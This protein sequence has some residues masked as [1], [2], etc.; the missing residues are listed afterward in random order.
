MAGLVLGTVGAVIG[1][2]FGL[3]SVGWMV[4]SAIG[5]MLDKKSAP[6][7]PMLN[8]LKIM[9]SAYGAHISRFWGTVRA[10]GKLID[11]TDKIPHAQHS[12]QGNKGG[13]G[14]VTGYTY[15]LTCAIMI[16]E[17]EITDIIKVYANSKLIYDISNGN[18]GHVGDLKYNMT[19]YKGT[20]DQLPDPSLEMIHGV[21]NTPAY[22]GRAYVVFRD[23][24]LSQ[25]GG[26]SNIPNFEFEV[27]RSPNSTNSHQSTKI[28]TPKN[29]FN[30]TKSQV[31]LGTVYNPINKFVYVA[32]AYEGYAL[33]IKKIDPNTNEVV[34][35][36]QVLPIGAISP[37]GTVRIS[38]YVD[39]TG[40]IIIPCFN[41]ENNHQSF[42][43]INPDSL[44]YQMLG[45]KGAGNSRFGTRFVTADNVTYYSFAHSSDG[46]GYSIFGGH[47]GET[48]KE[49][50]KLSPI[51]FRYTGDSFTINANDKLL[52]YPSYSSDSKTAYISAVDL[53]SGNIDETYLTLP[54]AGQNIVTV[55]DVYFDYVN[56]HLFVS[57]YGSSTQSSATMVRY[58]IDS[59]IVKTAQWGGTINGYGY[60]EEMFTVDTK[61]RRFLTNFAS[62]G[63]SFYALSAFSFDSMTQS[64]TQ[65]SIGD[66]NGISASPGSPSAYCPETDGQYFWGYKSTVTINAEINAQN[67]LLYNLMIPAEADRDKAA[68]ADCQAKITELTHLRDT[69]DEYIFINYGSRISDGNFALDQLITEVSLLAGLSLNDIDVTDLNGL[70]VRG[71]ATTNRH[72]ARTIVEQL[73]QIFFYDAVESNGKITFKK[74]GRTVSE[75]ITQDKLGAQIWSTNPKFDKNIEI[76]RIQEQELPKVANLIY[77]D[78]NKNKQQNNQNTIRIVKSSQNTMTVEVPIVLTADEAKSVI[79]SLTFMLWSSREKYIFQTN[80]DYFYLEPT[81]VI[82]LE[83][84]NSIHRVRIT[85]KDEDKGIIKWEAESELSTVYTQQGVGSSTSAISAGLTTY[86]PTELS[87]L[88]IP[89]LSEN[90]NDSGIYYVVKRTNPTLR[91]NGAE[92]DS[93]AINTGEFLAI[94]QTSIESIT[95]HTTSILGSFSNDN[96]IDRFNSFTIYTNSVL[97]SVNYDQLLN[98]YNLCLI[99]NELIQ[100]QV[101]NLIDKNTY[102]LSG[103]LRGRFGTESYINIHEINEKFVFFNSYNGS[104]KRILKD[105]SNINHPIYLKASTFGTKQ[106]DAQPIYFNNSAN[107]LKP[108]SVCHVRGNRDNVGNIN[109]NWF[110]RVRGVGVLKDG[111]DVNDIDSDS[112]EIDILNG[113]NVI[114]T[115]KTN[116]LNAI[117]SSAQQVADFG[118]NQNSLNINI[119]KMNSIIGRGFVK[120]KTI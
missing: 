33:Y 103:L 69:D 2:P 76:R 51:N 34:T 18:T 95:G 26:G 59:G 107:G 6:D 24:D 83:R 112:Y 79:D 56:R 73:S 82:E 46:G 88:D 85:K 5:G 89:I 19:V 37:N 12:S 92:I 15:S 20:E 81:D 52:Y 13:S 114:R 36:S 80:Y 10:A 4:G 54:N 3:A 101:A 97:N 14:P 90:D 99:G 49:L 22:R 23:L 109:I 61:N 25:F 65:Y 7:A 47:L 58:D 8:D 117:Y 28:V 113:L 86:S 40:N 119:Y 29:P 100:F 16:G 94:N 41:T 62:F 115:I 38:M 35:V 98:G 50:L 21:G 106:D 30:I 96:V 120:N 42:A 118:I 78:Y 71:Y 64:D 70:Q 84:N 55:G 67:S 93:S 91:W 66:T 87:L 110:K 32:C 63:G 111:I 45:K 17:G 39:Y 72:S 9:S 48:Y 11:S 43:S 60:P 53:I 116:T 44:T 105:S 57:Y 27:V 31:Q 68:I 75:R 74:R 77:F 104:L 1:A 102:V 108:Y